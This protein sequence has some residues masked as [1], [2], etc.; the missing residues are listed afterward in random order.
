M[1]LK[2]IEEFGRDGFLWLGF[3]LYVVEGKTKDRGGSG[4]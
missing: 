3:I 4:G 1:S 2:H